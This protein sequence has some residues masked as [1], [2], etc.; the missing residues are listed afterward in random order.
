MSAPLR[1]YL[2]VLFG[3]I[4]SSISFAFAYSNNDLSDRRG[5]SASAISGWVISNVQY[6]FASDPTQLSAIEFDLNSSAGEVRVK[7]SSKSPGYF[8]CFNTGD[9]HWHCHTS[10]VVVANMDEL[11]VIAMNK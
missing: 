9:Y 3:L 6:K 11:R 2:L 4:F 7:L 10:G 1:F 8:T 5:E